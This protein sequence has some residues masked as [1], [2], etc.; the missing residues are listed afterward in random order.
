MSI[1]FLKIHC[2]LL[3][4]HASDPS[5]WE[6]EADGSLRFEASLV[7]RVSSRTARVTQENCL[8]QPQHNPKEEIQFSSKLQKFSNSLYTLEMQVQL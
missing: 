3:V 4:V 8:K 2:R 5:T 1:Y 7:R 6:E